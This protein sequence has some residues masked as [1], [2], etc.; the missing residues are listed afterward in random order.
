MV[1][2]PRHPSCSYLSLP[3]LLRMYRPRQSVARASGGFGC[4]RG[5]RA[6]PGNVWL[7]DHSRHWRAPHQDHTL[8][9]LLHGARCVP[10]SVPTCSSRL[11]LHDCCLAGSRCICFKQTGL[12][13]HVLPAPLLILLLAIHRYL[14]HHL[15]ADL[16][17]S[18]LNCTHLIRVVCSDIARR[19]HWLLPG[20]PPLHHPLH[21]RR[22]HRCWPA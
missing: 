14:K 2:R 13:A 21:C 10:T 5:H 15:L 6:W 1:H 19:R 9:W 22:H 4:R 3:A 17:Q 16:R 8:S 11:L 20:P 7:Q 12:V 18:T